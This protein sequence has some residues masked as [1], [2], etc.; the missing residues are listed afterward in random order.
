[1]KRTNLQ[2]YIMTM[3]GAGLWG[4]IGL[5]VNPLYKEGFTAWE[6]VA[7]RGVFTFV[8]LFIF[9]LIRFP[10]LLKT[11]LKDHINFA[12]AGI[13]STALFNY[14]YFEVFS[15]STLSLAVTLLYTGPIFV[16]ILS[17]IF[18]KEAFTIKKILA[19]II[20]VFGCSFVVGFLPSGDI[21]VS[22]SVL[23]L[24]LLSGFC[25]ALYTIFSK[26]ITRKYS[27]LT[28]TTYNFLYTAIF[29]LIFSDITTKANQ[30]T[31]IEVLTPSIALSLIATVLAYLLYTSGLK[32]LEAS[33]ASILSTMEPII[34]ILS[35]VIFLGDVLNIWQI[36]GI[37]LV[38]TSAAIIGNL[39]LKIRRKNSKNKVI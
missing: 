7:I 5:F 13:L 9:M 6:V 38:I 4:T 1:M 23:I 2:T 24:G 3:C 19:L 35:G 39:N 25:F 10:H 37:L 31:K 30:F 20:A 26:P 16:T 33:T 11:N 34:A 32:N 29:M 17:R 22:I 14:F 28:I 15:Q 8:F 36:I 27:A 12:C 21:E 18:F